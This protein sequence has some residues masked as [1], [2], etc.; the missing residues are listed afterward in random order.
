MKQ[1]HASR[2]S[3]LPVLHDIPGCCKFLPSFNR[4]TSVV[5][6]SVKPEYLS[7]ELFARSPESKSLRQVWQQ[8]SIEAREEIERRAKANGCSILDQLSLSFPAAAQ[9]EC[10]RVETRHQRTVPPT[11]SELIEVMDNLVELMKQ[12]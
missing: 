5:P 8:L 12:S 11:L 9:M 2:K 1:L 4:I 10:W 7:G 6:V 3:T